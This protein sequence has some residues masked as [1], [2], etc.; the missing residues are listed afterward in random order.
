MAQAAAPALR[1]TLLGTVLGVLPGGGA[2]LSSFLSYAVEKRIARDPSRFGNGAIEGV[3]GP[4]AANNA[5]AQTSFIPMLTLGIPSNVIMALM[6]GAFIMH[7]IQPGPGLLREQPALV[8]GLIVSM[9]IGNVMLVLLNLPLVGLW[10]RLAT[11]P[12]R[13]LFPA[14]LVLCAIGVFTLN[15]AIF[16]IYTMIAFGLVGFVLRRLKC[17]PAP[18]I[19]AIVLGPM[20]EQYLRRA[21]LLSKGDFGVF[22]SRPLSGTFLVLAAVVLLAVAGPAIR[23]RRN[24]AMAE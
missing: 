12:Y 13:A 23:R 15:N 1:G 4:E 11:I 17:E 10:V 22:V 18:F 6:A 5:G 20:I 14:I 24:E 21:M 8:W 3:A 9:W 2:L 7:G 16:D 19:I